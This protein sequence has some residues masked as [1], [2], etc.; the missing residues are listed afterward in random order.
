MKAIYKYPLVIEANQHLILP[1]GS[2]I[3]SVQEQ[4]GELVL[5]AII[6]IGMAIKERRLISVYGT[7]FNMEDNAMNE[8]WHIQTV[9]MKNGLVWHV[10]ERDNYE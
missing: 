8:S 9:C 7:V 2:V 10:F 1:V 6:D 3:L 4:F 5:W